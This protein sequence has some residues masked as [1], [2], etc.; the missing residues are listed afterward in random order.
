LVKVIV[1]FA[2]DLKSPF[3]GGPLVDDDVAGEVDRLAGPAEVVVDIRKDVPEN[4][5]AAGPWASAA[6]VAAIASLPREG[7]ESGAAG[8]TRDVRPSSGSAADGAEKRRRRV[9]LIDKDI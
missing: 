6:G 3:W 8:A 2:I 7:R 5:R 1:P 9:A 4:D